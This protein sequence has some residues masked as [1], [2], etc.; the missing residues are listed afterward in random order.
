MA[1]LEVKSFAQ[2][3]EFQKLERFTE[4]RNMSRNNL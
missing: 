4:R 3:D 1:G 2:P